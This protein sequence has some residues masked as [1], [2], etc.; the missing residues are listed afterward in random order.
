MNDFPVGITALWNHIEPVE[1][2]KVDG[3]RRFVL[4]KNWGGSNW[5]PVS[6]LSTIP[7]K[8]PIN[9]IS[10]DAQFLREMA[11]VKQQHQEA[12]EVVYKQQRRIEELEAQIEE[13]ASIKRMMENGAPNEE[14]ARA[15]HRKIE[16]AFDEAEQYF[17]PAGPDDTP[18]CKTCGADILYCRCGRPKSKADL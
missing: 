13:N 1:I 17:Y 11:L 4:W 6:E 15:M 3:E 12:L 7:P 14:T 8:D 5:V 16:T 9:V 2:K 10:T 18:H